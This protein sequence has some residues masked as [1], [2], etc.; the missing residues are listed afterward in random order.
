[1]SKWIISAKNYAEID[2]L[3]MM[4]VS[5]CQVELIRNKITQNTQIN[6]TNGNKCAM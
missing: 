1:M 4:Q 3:A 2:N 5:N 6:A